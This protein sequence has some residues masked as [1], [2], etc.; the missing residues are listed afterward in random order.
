MWLKAADHDE[1]SENK[2]IAQQ[3]VGEETVNVSAK[4]QQKP[5]YSTP[6]ASGHPALMEKSNTAVHPKI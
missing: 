3:D 2:G 4:K 1:T 6:P 5:S